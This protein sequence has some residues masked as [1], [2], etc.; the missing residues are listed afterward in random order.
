M[1]KEKLE[2]I[3][4]LCFQKYNGVQDTGFVYLICDDQDNI[5]YIGST[6]DLRGRIYCHSMRPEFNGLNF[7]YTELDKTYKCRML[8]EELIYIASPAYNTN[9]KNRTKFLSH[10]LSI[11]KRQLIP[12]K[13]KINKI[14]EERS[15]TIN[16]LYKKT[17]LHRFTIANF[18]SMLNNKGN[19]HKSSLEKYK[20]ICEALGIEFDFK[21]R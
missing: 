7:Y 5:L 9:C 12:L 1:K 13:M 4:D 17:H 8:E 10:P 20:I 2:K 15:I 11:S 21:E 3:K 16:D 6:I 18:I 14:M 19:I